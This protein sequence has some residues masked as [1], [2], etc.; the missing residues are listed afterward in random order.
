VT[1]IEELKQAYATI[2]KL[3]DGKSP[4]IKGKEREFNVVEVTLWNMKG[5]WTRREWE[6][7]RKGD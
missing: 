2:K 7:E 5:E 1:E 4:W 3:I 6:M